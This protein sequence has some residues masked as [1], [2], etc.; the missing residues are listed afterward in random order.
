MRRGWLGIGL[1]LLAGCGA[2]QIGPD[3]EAFRAVDALYTAIS[4]RDAAQTGRCARAL[5]ALHEQGRLPEAAHRRLA[6][7]IAN[8]HRDRESWEAARARLRD[9]MKAQRGA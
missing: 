6:D 5:A 2:P 1:L 3:E 4:L 7:I 9:F 8:A